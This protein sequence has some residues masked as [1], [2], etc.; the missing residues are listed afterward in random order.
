MAQRGREGQPRR[1]DHR[2]GGAPLRPGP[3][4]RRA[5]RR[6][7]R[8]PADRRERPRRGSALAAR[9]DRRGARR[10]S[11]AARRAD[12]AARGAQVAARRRHARCRSTSRR[13]TSRTC[14]CA[15]SGKT[16]RRAGRQARLHRSRSRTCR[17]STGAT[18]RCRASTTAT[19][20]ATTTRRRSPAVASRASSRRGATSRSRSG[21]LRRIGAPQGTF[22]KDA[23]GDVGRRRSARSRRC[24]TAAWA[25]PRARS[26]RPA[27]KGKLGIHHGVARADKALPEI[28][29]LI[30]KEQFELI[31]QPASGIVV[32]QGGAGSGKTTVALHRDRVPELPGPAAVQAA[33]TRCSSCR[34]RRSCATSPACCPSLGVAG[35]PVVTYTGW[36]RSTRMRCLPD[37]PTKYNA[38]PPEQVSRVKKHPALLGDPRA[39]GRARRPRQIGAEL[40][41][42]VGARPRRASGTRLGKRALVP[43]LAALSAW[44]EEGRSSSRTCASRSRASSSAGR[45]APTTACSTGP[46][47]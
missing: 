41:E 44:A 47:C 39:L 31:T 42:H 28:A 35:V 27:Q 8:A 21:N 36:A 43:R 38:E 17:S 25:R 4:A 16:P 33:A 9:S 13:R 12:D 18:R 5:G 46:S 6:G 2:G 3:G 45:S 29:A 24:S 1:E 11:A 32:I 7:R 34:R 15:S 20:R 22:L 23:R 14:G 26:R 40:A 30:D 19:K 10:G 37:A